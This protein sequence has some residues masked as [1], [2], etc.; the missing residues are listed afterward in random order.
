MKQG[1]LT[2]ITDLIQKANKIIEKNGT[3]R[4]ASEAMQTLNLRSAE[5]KSETFDD[6]RG[7]TSSTDSVASE[8]TDLGNLI[9]TYEEEADP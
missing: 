4:S 1:D 2:S 7:R 5:L 8:A 6:S 9:F 3:G